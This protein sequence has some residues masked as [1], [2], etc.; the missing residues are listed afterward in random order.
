MMN[1]NPASLITLR[2]L[3][4]QRDRLSVIARLVCFL[5]GPFLVSHKRTHPTTTFLWLWQP[6]R[7]NQLD[8][9]SPVHRYAVPNKQGPLRLSPLS[10]RR[11]A[12]PDLIKTVAEPLNDRI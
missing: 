2:N 5:I 8:T 9:L 4:V 7:K 3:S 1:V 6:V 10:P 12:T 11:C